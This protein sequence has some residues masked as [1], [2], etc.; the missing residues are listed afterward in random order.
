[1]RNCYIGASINILLRYRNR[2]EGGGGDGRL[3]SDA[4]EEIWWIFG[5]GDYYGGW[6]FGCQ[7]VKQCNMYIIEYA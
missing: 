5:K 6:L 1:L 3:E 2:D 7:R 4:D